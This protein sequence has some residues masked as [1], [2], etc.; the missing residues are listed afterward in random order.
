[1][2]Q[3]SLGATGRIRR[4]AA[5]ALR[6]APRVTRIRRR[7]FLLLMSAPA[8]LASSSRGLFAVCAPG[9]AVSQQGGQA[10]SDPRTIRVASNLVLVPVSVSDEAGRIVADLEAADFSI[11]E[12][13]RGV[14]AVKLGEPG[15]VPLDLAL[16]LDISGSLNP[17]FEFQLQAAIRF[18]RKVVRDQDTVTLLTVESHPRILTER[19]PSVDEAIGQLQCLHPTFEATAFYDA[20][21]K[22]TRTFGPR[23]PA[24]SRRALVALSDGEDN[25]SENTKLQESIQA[26]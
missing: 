10:A 20:V 9:S 17:R 12:D 13:G 25:R 15:E 5:A 22:A 11:E 14:T 1:M 8:A 19:T 24:G 23:P 4:N 3:A 2:Q 16:L 21:V 6:S 7:E 26:V 18:L